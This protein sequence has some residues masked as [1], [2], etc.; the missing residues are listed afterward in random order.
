MSY[1]VLTQN[2][3]VISRTTVQRVT[4]LE[5]EVLENQETFSEFDEQIKGIIKEDDFPLERNNPNPADWADILEDNE[6][7]QEEFNQIYQDLDIPE[8]DDTFTPDLM[9]DTNRNMEVAL[10]R[11]SEGPEFA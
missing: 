7:F 9:D 6:D 4:N 2:G 8:A 1:W 11:D 10:P 5:S 3:Y